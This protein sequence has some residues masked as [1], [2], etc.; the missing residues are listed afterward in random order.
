MHRPVRWVTTDDT[1]RTAARIMRDENVG[2]VIVCDSSGRALGTVTDR[3]IALRLVADDH[4]PG[5]RIES[6][7]T[8]GTVTC[9]PDDDVDIAERL[10]QRFHKSRIVCTDDGGHPVGV[11]SLADLAQ[12][13]SPER[14]GRLLREITSREA[15][16]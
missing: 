8:A 5:A 6:V 4:V 7:M 10:M 13:E 16:H 11:I 3:D 14:V 1:V 15:R 9:R 2:F 12:Y